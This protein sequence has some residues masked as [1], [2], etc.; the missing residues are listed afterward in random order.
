M[1]VG[2]IT[3]LYE[4]H[5]WANRRLFDTAAALGEEAAAREVG[6]QFSYPTLVRMFA[7]LY[8]ADGVWLARWRGTSPARLPGSELTTLAEVRR[9]WDPLEQD[10]RAFIE[11]LTEADLDRIVDYANTEGRRFRLALGP[12]LQHVANHATHHRSEVATM[13]TMISASP[14]DTG[15]ALHQLVTTGQMP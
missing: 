8:G 11:G 7:H 9:A 5:R 1:A 13:I 15:M 12:L 10:Q 4:Y 3:G 6:G 14:P 2:W